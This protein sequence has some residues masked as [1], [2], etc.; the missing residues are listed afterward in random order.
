MRKLIVI[1]ITHL[2]LI[3]PKLGAQEKQT[4]TPL[5]V[6]GS[7]TYQ[8]SIGGLYPNGQNTP[9]SAH[10]AQ[11]K[12]ACAQLAADDEI[13]FM[14]L[15]A[16]NLATEFEQT[17]IQFQNLIGHNQNV[18]MVNTARG[19]QT[20]DKFTVDDYLNTFVPGILTAR[21]YTSADVDV[22]W[23]KTAYLKTNI[24]SMGFTGFLNSVEPMYQDAIELINQQFPNV[25]LILFS[26]RHNTLQITGT[27]A[28]AQHAEPGAY[29]DSWAI[30]NTI[31][32]QING[33]AFNYAD[34]PTLMFA[35]PFYTQ[36]Y[37]I[38]N[39]FGHTL[40]ST[41]VATDNPHPTAPARVSHAAYVID[42]LKNDSLLSQWF[43]S[44]SAPP[45]PQRTSYYVGVNGANSTE[46]MTGEVKQYVVDAT[47]NNTFVFRYRPTHSGTGG[48]AAGKGFPSDID[49]V[50]SL[51]NYFNTHDKKI[52]IIYCLDLQTDATSNYNAIEYLL[53]KSV[54]VKCIEAGNEEYAREKFNFVFASYKAAFRPVQD[55]INAKYPTIPFSIFLAPRPSDG[56]MAGGRSEHKTFNDAVINYMRTEADPE[57]EI[58]IHI[59]FN[60]AEI[61]ALSDTSLP[62]TVNHNSNTYFAII[63]I[64]G[65]SFKYKQ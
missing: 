47:G 62:Q 65:E 3:S 26:G 59:Y 53:N 10:I 33:S 54:P 42:Y 15:G 30:K 5:D 46:V 11:I 6:L 44:P 58:S 43:M 16:S 17:E 60:S 35:F 19:S 4:Y 41:D 48:A 1:L 64:F 56:G 21:G 57:D 32:K 20:L 22:V 12:S 52:T 9:P 34:Y 50:V 18:V 39:T 51:V 61:A 25:K 40:K 14:P 49:S 36:D 38:A 31:A 7:G 37:G 55:L 24:S 63:V 13:V 8:G 2:I 29:W 23:M 27:G 28:Y 45:A